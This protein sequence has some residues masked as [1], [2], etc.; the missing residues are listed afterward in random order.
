MTRTLET[1]QVSH[2][3]LA[4]QII[5]TTGYEEA[6]ALGLLAGINAALKAG[7]GQPFYSDRTQSYLGVMVDD[8][9]TRGTQ[10]PYRMFTSRAEYRLLLRADN[11]DQR[12]TADGIISWRG[13]IGATAAWAIK[14][15]GSGAGAGVVD[16]V[17]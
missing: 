1:K 9:V 10:E 8:L 7:G 14:S 3:F 16:H 12:L 11:A 6:G 2:L 13:G 4:G 5:G 17:H 15:S